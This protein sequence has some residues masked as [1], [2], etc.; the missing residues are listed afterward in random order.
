[1]VSQFS[2]WR[3]SIGNSFSVYGV[4]MCVCLCQREPTPEIDVQV[5]IPEPLKKWLTDDWD[6]I[7]K[8]KQV[9]GRRVGL[10]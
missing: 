2:E 5:E 1:M 3:T 10:V 4:C 7:I 6:F 8:Q 9:K